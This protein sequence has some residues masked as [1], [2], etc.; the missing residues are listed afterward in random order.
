MNEHD[1]SPTPR[2]WSGMDAAVPDDADPQ[3]LLE[4]VL[5]LV[6]PLTLLDEVRQ[7]ELPMMPYRPLAGELLV[8][9]VLNEDGSVGYVN[10]RHL[11]TWNVTEAELHERA[12]ENLRNK[13]WTPY[14]GVLGAGKGALL[15]LNRR[16]GYDAARVLL[17]E[18]FAEFQ[19]RVPGTMVIG[20]PNR[21]FLIAFSDADQRVFAQVVAQ[22]EADARAQAHPLTA[23]LFTFN[24]GELVV[25]N[26]PQA[27]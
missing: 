13:A 2:Q 1:P 6:K 19:A 27:N 11:R 16:D 8:V 23:Q 10:E 5:P 14:P 3:R 15:I 21:D 24:G 25:Y 22:I 20:I 17:P 9:Y 26:P 12:L 18:L 7:R 4:R